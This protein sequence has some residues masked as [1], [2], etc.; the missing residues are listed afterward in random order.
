MTAIVNGTMS[1]LKFIDISLDT[2]IINNAS[3]ILDI[4]INDLGSNIWELTLANSLTLTDFTV[5]STSKL[6][7]DMLDEMHS[8]IL[9]I[10]NE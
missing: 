6:V 7:N 9:K 8:E 10:V 2:L 4:G 1:F 3:L 5:N